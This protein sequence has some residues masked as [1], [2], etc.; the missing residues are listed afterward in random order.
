MYSPIAS[1]AA[2]RRWIVVSGVIGA[3][4]GSL[5]LADCATPSNHAEP[6]PRGHPPT[7][8][9]PTS[10]LSIDLVH[11]GAAG[12][13]AGGR[14]RFTNH[15]PVTCS[16]TGWPDLVAVTAGGTKRRAVQ[17]RT[18]MFGPH[19]AA[20]SP[21]VTMRHG[22]SAEAVFTVGD[23]PRS[24]RHCPSPY[25]RLRIT[26]PGDTTRVTLSAWLPGYGYL[27]ACTPLNVSPVVAPAAA[28]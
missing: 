13:M 15:S 17:R 7:R 9:C 20:S 2:S 26:P 25:H 24:G 1:H 28:G 3:A 11:T 5:V 6:P 23:H 19:P 12:G 10:H 8:T 16:L 14:I 18:T 27:P 21:I 4:F 22:G